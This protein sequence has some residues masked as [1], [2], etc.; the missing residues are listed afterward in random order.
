M[1]LGWVTFFFGSLFGG[2]FLEGEGITGWP[3]MLLSRSLKCDKWLLKLA[4]TRPTKNSLVLLL[5][6]ER[7]PRYINEEV[8]KCG[9][10]S[11]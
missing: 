9:P 8:E 7:I 10:P 4:M 6:V 11:L 3:T 2:M 1:I 5:R